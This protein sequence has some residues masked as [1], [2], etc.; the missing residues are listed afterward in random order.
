LGLSRPPPLTH[1]GHLPGWDLTKAPNQ[2]FYR[3]TEVCGPWGA[4]CKVLKVSFLFGSCQ[5][6]PARPPDH[7]LL[8]QY[9]SA[10]FPA[11]ECCVRGRLSKQAGQVILNS[12]GCIILI[13][14]NVHDIRKFAWKG[15]FYNAVRI[16][17]EC[18][19][20]WSARCRCLPRAVC[21]SGVEKSW[22]AQA[23]CSHL[24]SQQTG[25]SSSSTSSGLLQQILLQHS[26]MH[27]TAASLGQQ[28]KHT[29]IRTHA[30]ACVMGFAILSASLATLPHLSAFANSL[31]SYEP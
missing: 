26:A 21:Q 7:F 19:W 15:P 9:P 23:H 16:S 12:M 11:C 27:I 13:L 5:K 4:V 18:P 29:C 24:P 28:G 20:A 3:A 8:V 6:S 30:Y 10:H 17:L 1:P 25:N 31:H 2:T 22:P 14:S